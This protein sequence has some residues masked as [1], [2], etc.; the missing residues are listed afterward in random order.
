VATILIA[1][2]EPNVRTFVS[3]LLKTD[4]HTVIEAQDGTEALSL[5]QSRSPDLLILDVRMPEKSGFEV[6][7]RLQAAEGHEDKRV[8]FLTG[9]TDEEDHLKGW[10]YG[11][12][13]YLTKPIDGD[14]LLIAV[15]D[16]LAL[17]PDQRQENRDREIERAR[18]LRQLDRFL[19]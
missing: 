9:A 1:D 2:D 12:D 6:L 7:R 10:T 4:G 3:T 16:V 5:A 13:G 14:E 18:L 15:A 17:T 19:E 11:A 8:L